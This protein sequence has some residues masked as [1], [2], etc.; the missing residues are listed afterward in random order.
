MMSN[1]DIARANWRADLQDYTAAV[2]RD[3]GLDALADSNE[4]SAAQHR[5]YADLMAELDAAK[6]AYK[7][8]SKT[9]ADTA[10]YQ[11]AKV[12]ISTARQAMRE[13]GAPR[14]GVL[15]NFSEPTAAELKDLGY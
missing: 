7:A 13:T 9:E 15:D 6:A 11:A 2:M 8:S 14:P 5:A 1:V 12:A 10:A 3:A 4:A